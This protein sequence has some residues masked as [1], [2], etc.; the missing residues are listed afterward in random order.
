MINFFSQDHSSGNNV[1]GIFASLLRCFENCESARKAIRR[2]KSEF[3]KLYEEEFLTTLESSDLSSAVR[4]LL[5]LQGLDKSEPTFLLTQSLNL[6][7]LPETELTSDSKSQLAIFII[8]E[9]KATRSDGWISE[10]N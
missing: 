10:V 6:L 5:L 8:N 7:R 1:P 2:L 4:S 3:L 9:V